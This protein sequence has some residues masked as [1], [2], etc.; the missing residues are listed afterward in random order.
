MICGDPANI[1]NEADLAIRTIASLG[2][3]GILVLQVRIL[4]QR[5]SS[6]D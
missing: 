2:I 4:L 6:R 5:N 3:V 1:P